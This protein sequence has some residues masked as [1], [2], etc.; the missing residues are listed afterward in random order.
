[1]F[2]VPIRT[3]LIMYVAVY[4]CL[5]ANQKGGHLYRLKC[6][7]EKLFFENI[8]SYNFCCIKLNMSSLISSWI[9]STYVPINFLACFFLLKESNYIQKP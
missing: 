3:Y 6:Y 2:K 5:G 8:K 4:I 7:M 1:M 9:I